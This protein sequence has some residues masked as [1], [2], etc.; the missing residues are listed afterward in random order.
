MADHPGAGTEPRNPSDDATAPLARL[1]LVEDDERVASA[2]VPALCRAGYDVSHVSTGTAALAQAATVD[3]VLLDLGLPDID[4]VEVCRRLREDSD[5]PIIA[6]TARGGA[7]DRV[8]GLRTGADDYIVK[9]FSL[10]ELTARIEAVL[11]RAGTDDP[12][13]QFQQVGGL[14]IDG[15]SHSVTF[16]GRLIQLTRKEYDLL[17]LLASDP[18]RVFT[19]AELLEEV[20]HTSWEGR[21]R[22]VDV[23]VANVRQKLGEPT[24]IRTVHGVGYQLN[25]AE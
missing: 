2:V 3:L 20:W 15:S 9:P 25:V 14:E 12:R 1:L 8:L 11:R 24:V 4:G 23:H 7:P 13:H 10:A 16:C 5:I 21:S 18:G 22:T 19:R 6:V 17:A